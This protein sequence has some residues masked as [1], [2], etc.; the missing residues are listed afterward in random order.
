MK[1]YGPLPDRESIHLVALLMVSGLSPPTNRGH[2]PVP[3]V[4]L[5]FVPSLCAPLPDLGTS[6]LQPIGHNVPTPLLVLIPTAQILSQPFFPLPAH[7]PKVAKS[8]SPSDTWR[9]PHRWESLNSQRSSFPGRHPLPLRSSQIYKHSLS[10]SPP[11]HPPPERVGIRF[12]GARHISSQQ[13]GSWIPPHRCA[14]HAL[15]QNVAIGKNRDPSCTHH[16]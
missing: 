16:F 4:T 11:S 6:L 14:P 12:E 5:V 15:Y 13:R 8:P 1:K 3:S 2:V 7:P 9:S 10:F